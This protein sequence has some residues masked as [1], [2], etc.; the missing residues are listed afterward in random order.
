MLFVVLR[1]SYTEL[2]CPNVLVKCTGKEMVQLMDVCWSWCVDTGNYNRDHSDIIG[3][4][5]VCLCACERAYVYVCV[6]AFMH[7][8]VVCVHTCVHVCVYLRVCVCACV[9]VCMC[10]CRCVCMCACVRRCVCVHA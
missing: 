5:C 7:V 10:V 6:R 4:W 9:C 1:S 2:N 3:V 8:F